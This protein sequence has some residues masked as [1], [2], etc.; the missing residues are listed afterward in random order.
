MQ[1]LT[2]CR[3]SDIKYVTD[4]FSKNIT[5]VCSWCSSRGLQ[6]NASKTELWFGSASRM[7]RLDP[8]SARII[9]DKS[10]DIMPVK[11]VRDLGVYFDNEL[12]MRE[13]VS[14]T[15]RSCFCQLR[16]LRP[17]RRHLGQDVMKRLVCSS[18]SSSRHFFYAAY[19]ER[20]QRR[21]S[22]SLM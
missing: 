18:S 5:D 16:R 9:L 22:K 11:V 1:G 2:S 7:R 19:T 14:R 13:Y 12:S 3:S 6:L 17:E 20:D 8:E 4:A 21:I 10:T 15:A